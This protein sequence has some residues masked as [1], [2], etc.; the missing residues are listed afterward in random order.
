MAALLAVVRSRLPGSTSRRSGAMRLIDAGLAALLAGVLLQMVPLPAAVVRAVSPGRD[1]YLAAAS[2]QPPV[3]PAFAPLTLDVAATAHAWLTLFCIAATFWTARAIFQTG[4]I[5]TFS[6]AIAWGS[7]VLALVAF[8]Q[9]ASGTALVYGFWQPQDAGTRPLGPFVNRNHLGTWSVMAAC[10]CAGYLQWRADGRTAPRT[11]RAR[12]AAALDGRGLVLLLAV[13]LL[14]AVIALGAS[15]SSL[16]ALAGAAVYVAFAAG[17]GRRASL[18][19]LAAVS[20]AAML[21]YGDAQRL[22]LRVD[23]T[24]IGGM[25]NRV[26]IWRDAVPVVRDFPVTG[27]GAGAFGRAMRVYQTTPRAYYHNEAHNQYLQLAAEGGL[28]LTVP[29]AAAVVALVL[30]AGAQ[31]RRRGDR[32]RWM[33]VGAAGAL[34]G[35]AVQ[36]IW[37]TG[38]TLPANGMFAAALAALLVHTPPPATSKESR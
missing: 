20:V 6:S 21:G 28:L 11:C 33:R 38:L 24:R 10:L 30:A 25:A 23:E 22:L 17:E 34:V 8:A 36:S 7:I 29:A 15:R 4:G 18:G 13:V 16:V 32:V 14:A 12:V 5:R 9:H 3:P 2:L 19:I 37:E 1:A 35:V 27:V 26:A 31:L